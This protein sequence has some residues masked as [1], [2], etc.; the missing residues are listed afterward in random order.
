VVPAR[1][2]QTRSPQRSLVRSLSRLMSSQCY[3]K[4]NKNYSAKL[5]TAVQV[6]WC[7]FSAAVA[8][9][10]QYSREMRAASAKAREVTASP[11]ASRSA[12]ALAI[13]VASAARRASANG[14]PSGVNCGKVVHGASRA[15]TV[16]HPRTASR[17]PAHH[18]VAAGCD[19]PT[20]VSSARTSASATRLASED[21]GSA[22]S[23][24]PRARLTH[25]S[26]SGSA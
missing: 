11:R 2:A 13:L 24:P 1:L 4:C 17:P 12:A 3:Q 19:V 6:P 20:R 18:G 16:P 5:I 7:P 23:H 21:R 14:N 25:L 22:R 26:A 8:R 9:H 15:D 10:K